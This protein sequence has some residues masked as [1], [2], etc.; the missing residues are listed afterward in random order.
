VLD[1]ADTPTLLITTVDTPVDTELPVAV[2]IELVKAC[3]TPVTVLAPVLVATP[4]FVDPELLV[5]A[6]TLVPVLLPT[7]ALVT[8]LYPVT[9]PIPATVATLLATAPPMPDALLVPVLVPSPE[10]Y[11]GP[12]ED[13]PNEKGNINSVGWNMLGRCSS[14]RISAGGMPLFQIAASNIPD[15]YAARTP[16]LGNPPT[17]MDDPEDAKPFGTVPDT[18]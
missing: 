1:P 4:D 18:S 6:T 14:A 10:A 11:V 7:I 3:A 8:A 13:S 5:A 9:I 15:T 16:Y 2:P 17:N 12:P